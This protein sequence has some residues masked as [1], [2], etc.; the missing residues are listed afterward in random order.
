MRRP[1]KTARN[2]WFQ[3]LPCASRWGAEVHAL[4]KSV[5]FACAVLLAMLVFSPI[6][7]THKGFE[8]FPSTTELIGV[9]LVLVL[10]LA[11][12][13]SLVVG[14]VSSLRNSRT[15]RHTR[16]ARRIE[17]RTPR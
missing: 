13:V 9:F 2:Y 7:T 8:F 14:A 16:H 11:V 12:A 1:A 6:P 15:D 5:A 3:W 17:G 4:K 10:F